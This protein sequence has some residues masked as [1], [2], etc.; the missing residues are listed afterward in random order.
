MCYAYRK[1][2]MMLKQHLQIS[3]VRIRSKCRQILAKSIAT[4]KNLTQ[5][6]FLRRN[7]NNYK[8]CVIVLC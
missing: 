6:K 7:K 2:L 5:M 3:N 1:V 4:Q 8:S